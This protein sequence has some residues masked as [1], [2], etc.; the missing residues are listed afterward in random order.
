[1]WKAQKSNAISHRTSPKAKAINAV[2]KELRDFKTVESTC[3]PHKK[4]QEYESVRYFNLMNLL[5]QS[6]TLYSKEQLFS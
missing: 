5:F 4:R 1:M 6:I 3:S 2:A